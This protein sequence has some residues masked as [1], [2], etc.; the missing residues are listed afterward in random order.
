MSQAKVPLVNRLREYPAEGVDLENMVD[1]PPRIQPIPVNPLFFD[2]AWNYIDYP[3]NLPAATSKLE[4][5]PT[6]TPE[7]KKRGWFGFGR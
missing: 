3:G 4:G 1:Y 6:S 5:E 7:P 2:V